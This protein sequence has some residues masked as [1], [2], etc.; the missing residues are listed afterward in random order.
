MRLN[1]L[2]SF[3]GFILIIAGTYCPMV[4]PLHLYNI[5]VY[6]GSKPYGIVMLLIAAV[7]IISAVFSQAVTIRFCAWASLVLVIL[8]YI[9]AWL[10][11]HTSFSFIPFHALDDY[12]TRKIRFMWGW[13]VLAAGAVMAIA[14][15]LITNRPK[16][17]GQFK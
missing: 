7:G 15:T 2:V 6:G 12:L 11:V 1:N 14:G 4:R 8:F 17:A 3:V 9:L 16:L 5:D 10:K 13:Y